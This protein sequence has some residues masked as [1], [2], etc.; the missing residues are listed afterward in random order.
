MK[1]EMRK[2]DTIQIEVSLT[3]NGEPFV[4]DGELVVFS[5]GR[6]LCRNPIFTTPVIDGVAY[7][8]HNMTADMRVGLYKY[9]VRV[10]TSDKTLVSTPCYGDFELLGVVNNGL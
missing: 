9:D 10:Y 1:I 7:I 5:V 6:A 2:G 8:T 4:P 3:N